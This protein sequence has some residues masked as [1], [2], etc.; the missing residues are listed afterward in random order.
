[1]T[2]T[3]WYKRDEPIGYVDEALSGGVRQALP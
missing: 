3:G 1:M 2:S